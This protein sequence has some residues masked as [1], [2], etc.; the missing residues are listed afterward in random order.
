MWNRLLFAAL[1]IIVFSS[2]EDSMILKSEK[3][4]KE[5]IQGTW[6][7]SFQGSIK[8]ITKCPTVF[9]SSSYDEYWMFKDDNFYSYY[10]YSPATG[11][12]RGTPD[13]NDA[14]NIDTALVCK[15]KIDTQILKAFLKFQ[16]ISGG[17]DTTGATF[18]DKWEF[19]TLDSKIL[20][21][22]TDTKNGAGV[23]QREFS[24]VK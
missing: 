16:L 4:M 8:V 9:D 22:A 23:Q 6:L 24:K 2:C 18:Y 21:L 17:L 20:Y 5:D 13:L 19:V 12:D 1:I 10:M 7:R 14:D 15:F 3:K 11:C